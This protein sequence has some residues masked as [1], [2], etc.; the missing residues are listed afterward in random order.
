MFVYVCSK[1]GG[2]ERKRRQS[3]DVNK[4]GGVS[5]TSGPGVTS[6]VN[7]DGERT[8][9]RRSR[10]VYKYCGLPITVW[11]RNLTITRYVNK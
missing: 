4:N 7:K 11:R 8:C 9:F 1:H 10:D 3:R 2:M 5:M 6:H